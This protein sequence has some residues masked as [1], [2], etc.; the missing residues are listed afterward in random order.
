MSASQLIEPAKTGGG[1]VAPAQEFEYRPVPALVSVAGAF[2]FFSLTAFI[3]DWLLL[4]PVVGIMLAAIAL[5][6]I[7]RS[8]GAYGGE[9][10]AWVLVAVMAVQLASAAGLHAYAFATEVPDGF[11]RVSFPN[12]ISQYELKTVDGRLQIPEPVQVLDGQPVFLKGYMYPK[13]ETE[14]LTQFVLCKDMGQCCFGGNPKPTDM[15]VIKMD[16]GLRANQRT[17]LVSVAGVFHTQADIDEE[18]LNPVYQL[19]CSFFSVAK[20]AY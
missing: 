10:L 17:G 5:G 20:T 1:W 7:R 11:Q 16:K 3:L 15:I 2:A 14:G 13:R 18:G 6:Q 9:K 8:S 12:D 19:D 4:V